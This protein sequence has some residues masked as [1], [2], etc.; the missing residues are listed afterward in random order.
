MMSSVAETLKEIKAKLDE[1]DR[2]VLERAD[3]ADERAIEV[4][5][6]LRA[7]LDRFG[8]ESKQS[9][10][11]TAKDAVADFGEKL[12]ELK[13]AASEFYTELKRDKR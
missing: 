7:R 10:K 9:A 8:E 13:Q 5:G 2:V 1:L 12:E 11:E 3:A 4:L 6:K